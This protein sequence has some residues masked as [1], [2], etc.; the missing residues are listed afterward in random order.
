MAARPDA[1]AVS[2]VGAL[3][4]WPFYYLEVALHYLLGNAKRGAS[5]K[6]LQG[7]FSPVTAEVYE[8]ELEVEGE[9][10]PD[11]S[12]CFL[13]TGPNPQ[14]RPLGGYHWFDGDGMVHACRIKDG[15]VSYSNKWVKTQRYL[16][17]QAVGWPS[18]GKLGDLAG[19]GGLVCL[20]LSGVKRILGVI[21]DGRGTANTA[22]VY[23]AKRLLAL[24]EG[25][26]PY[27]LKV[28]CEGAVETVERVSFGE[29]KA[30]TAHPKVDHATGF[31][32]FFGYDLERRPHCTYGV[33]D[34]SGQLIKSVPIDIPKPVMMHDF[35]ITANHSIFLDT[36]L[37][38]DPKVMVKEGKLPFVFDKEKGLLFGVRPHAAAEGDKE[39]VKWFTLPAQ[40]IFHVAN[41][42]EDGDVIHVYACA[43]DYLDLNML[44]AEGVE[45][46]EDSLP[47]LHH[48]ALNMKDGSASATRLTNAI[49]DFPQ[50]DQRL[51]G[52]QTRYVYCASDKDM[53]NTTFGD[54]IKL[55]LQAGGDDIC[56]GRITLGAYKA[57]GEAIFV[58]RRA[59]ASEDDGYLLTYV[60]DQSNDTSEMVVYDAKTMSQSPLARVKLPQRVPYGFHALFMDEAQVA[61]QS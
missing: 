15:K 43:M 1:R 53:A 5:N 3:L 16:Q 33:V 47:Y 28:L 12:G 13:R 57:G 7:N 39:A 11:L 21:R 41:A 48:Y 8:T 14:Y 22:M 26:M 37:A 29:M 19:V 61:G 32:H 40:M 44:S 42:W 52:V 55:D 36:P 30:F 2:Q 46:G 60:Y 24:H 35:A 49:G 59:A 56:C 23:H 45:M 10:P 4:S 51:A 25:D 20:A 17:E 50:I 38:F 27:A 9:L 54:I 18:S 31:M 58:P 34:P 6:Y